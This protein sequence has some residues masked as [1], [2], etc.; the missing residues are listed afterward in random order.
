MKIIKRLTTITKY[1][2]LKKYVIKPTILQYNKNYKNKCMYVCKYIH[3][4][5]GLLI[6]LQMGCKFKCIIRNYKTNSMILHYF[7]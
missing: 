2:N 3:L 4:N 7:K 1:I 5:E 6:M